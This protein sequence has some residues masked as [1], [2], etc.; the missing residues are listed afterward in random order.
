MKWKTV[1]A[2]CF[3]GIFFCGSIGLAA[4]TPGK[5]E[6]LVL[7]GQVEGS[8]QEG[9]V[10]FVTPDGTIYTMDPGKNGGTLMSY[11]PFRALGVIKEIQGKKIFLLQKIESY[12]YPYKGKP[13]S[14]KK[15]KENTV[16]HKEMVRNEET[17]RDPAYYHEKLQ[18][19]QKTY[20]EDRISS[21]SSSETIKYET[22]STSKGLASGSKVAVTGSVISTQKEGVMNFRDDMGNYVKLHMNGLKLPL[23]QRAIV[24]GIV[25]DD[26]SIQAHKIIS[27]A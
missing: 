17:E 22:V 10:D 7:Y 20:Y 8:S 26:G 11:V 16:V 4:S 23:G 21:D 3:V 27:K 15:K 19:Y 9:Y 18:S 25:Q 5:D 2:L 12:Q 24:F 13:V 14:Y 1:A 6:N